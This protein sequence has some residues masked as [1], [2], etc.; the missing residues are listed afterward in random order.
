MAYF[1]ASLMALI[2]LVYQY[3]Q[4]DI[5]DDLFLWPIPIVCL[6]R[7]MDAQHHIIAFVLFS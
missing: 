7:H 5:D 6:K 4:R 3:Q 2:W 1:H